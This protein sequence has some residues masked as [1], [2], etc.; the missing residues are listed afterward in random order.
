MECD[1]NFREID[2][3]ESCP[4][5]K[6]VVCEYM[7]TCVSIYSQHIP[8]I[9]AVIYILTISVKHYKCFLFLRHFPLE[10]LV[11][12][13]LK[14]IGFRLRNFPTENSF[15]LE[16]FFSLENSLWARENV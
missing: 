15:C 11:L 7:D 4:A 12:P 3:K 8:L 5:R 14:K 13:S 6:F 1:V 16:Q 2:V 10:C 9:F